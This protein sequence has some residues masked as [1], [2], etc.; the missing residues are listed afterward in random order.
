LPNFKGHWKQWRHNLADD[1]NAVAP[2]RN[3]AVLLPGLI[4]ERNNPT[5]IHKPNKNSEQE[6]QLKVD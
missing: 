1:G 2:F 4:L 3:P 5:S 6:G